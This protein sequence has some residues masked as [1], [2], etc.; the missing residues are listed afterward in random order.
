MID[1]QTEVI[2]IVNG[3]REAYLRR[4]GSPWVFLLSQPGFVENRDQA[5][6]ACRYA[7][8]QLCMQQAPDRWSDRAYISTLL[9][10]NQQL[11]PYA[12]FSHAVQCLRWHPEVTLV[13]RG[14]SKDDDL[15][16]KSLLT[17]E[18]YYPEVPI[19]THA[20]P[21]SAPFDVYRDLLFEELS[22]PDYAGYALTRLLNLRQIRIDDIR[23]QQVL[24]Q[25]PTTLTDVAA[26][27]LAEER[28]FAAPD[29]C[30][31]I[32]AHAIAVNKFDEFLAAI[33][34]CDGTFI[35]WTPSD[36]QRDIAIQVDDGRR[37]AFSIPPTVEVQFLRL[38]QRRAYQ[39]EK[40]QNLLKVLKGA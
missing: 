35:G 8:D 31:K 27:A 12:G 24:E 20:G 2:A 40:A 37:I 25:H 13:D 32:L 22:S 9:D 3:K 21:L 33:E 38:S 18:A 29:L 5:E 26:Y 4:T 14:Y 36:E 19:P 28:T 7:L 34:L 16:L 6:P 17:L 15:H 10:L 30:A 23:V 39:T 1:W 11:K